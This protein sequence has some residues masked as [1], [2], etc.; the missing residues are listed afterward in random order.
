MPRRHATLQFASSSRSTGGAKTGCG[1]SAGG[2]MGR[3]AL[4]AARSDRSHPPAGW[5]HSGSASAAIRRSAARPRPHGGGL[6]SPD[7]HAA[8]PPP[9][10][11]TA[12][13]APDR[14]CR[15]QGLPAAAGDPGGYLLQL[16]GNNGGEQGVGLPLQARQDLRAAMGSEWMQGLHQNPLLM[17]LASDP[18]SETFPWGRCPSALP[19]RKQPSPPL[20]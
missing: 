5:V 12:G 14:C 17:A 3:L 11:A 10:A 7:R 13:A 18:R 2:W 4:V 20:H 6:P 19:R 16:A 1:A 15:W 9:L 8:L